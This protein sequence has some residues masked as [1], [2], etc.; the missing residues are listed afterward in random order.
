MTVA[1]AIYP[2]QGDEG[3]PKFGV[4]PELQA[5]AKADSIL[6]IAMTPRKIQD[7]STLEGNYVPLVVPIATTSL[8]AQSNVKQDVSSSSILSNG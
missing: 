4:L 2:D 3:D 6:Y 1:T 8:L 5:F 7:R